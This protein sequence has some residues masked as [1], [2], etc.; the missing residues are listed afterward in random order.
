M[1]SHQLRKRMYWLTLFFITLSGFAQMPI[2]KR[3]YIADIPGLGWLAQFYTTHTIHYV[4]AVVLITF[5]CYLAAQF[6]LER[7]TVAGITGAGMFKIGLV[8]GL[9]LTGGL[10][11]YKNL[12]GVYL[13]HTLISLLD[14]AHLGLCMLLLSAGLYSVVRKRKWLKA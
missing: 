6:L 2:F 8:A 10:L 14:L 13:D 12:P 11:A 5:V 3:Y 4:S 7:K 1:E 9:I